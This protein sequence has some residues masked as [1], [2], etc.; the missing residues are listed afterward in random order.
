MGKKRNVKK[1]KTWKTWT[2][3][4]AFVL[5]LFCFVDLLVLC[6]YFAF[7]FL[8]SPF[9]VPFIICFCVFFDFADL[10]FVVSFFCFCRAFFQVLKK[11]RMSGGLADIKFNYCL[12]DDFPVR[13]LLFFFTGG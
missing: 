11:V 5:H 6:F 13:K 12:N 2:C 9:F 1:G 10:F 8:F 7:I 4:F 3:P